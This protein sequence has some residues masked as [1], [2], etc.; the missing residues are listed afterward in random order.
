M[1]LVLVG[2]V[3]L[4]TVAFVIAWG[5]YGILARMI[6]PGLSGSL[7][8]AGRAYSLAAIERRALPV[9]L[10]AVVLFVVTGSYMLVINPQY[11]GLGSFSST[12]AVLMLAKHLLVV[13]LVGLGV[14]IDYLIRGLANWAKDEDRVKE[15][16]WIALAADGATGLGALIALLTAAAQLAV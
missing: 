13:V 14:L 15:M 16:R 11:S 2:A 9:V 8:V 7:D 6:L 3:W 10:L 4:H 5:Y 1:D 12:W